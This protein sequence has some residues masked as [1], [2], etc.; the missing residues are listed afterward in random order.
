MF[1]FAVL[2]ELRK[3]EG[4][5]I[6]LVSSR[7][8]VSPAVISKLERNKTQAEL[9]TLFKLARVFGLSATDLLSLA[10]SRTAQMKRGSDYSSGDFHFQRLHYSNATA[11]HGFAEAGAAVSRP[12][13]HRDE[14]EICWALKGS[15][16]IRLPNETHD[17]A[18]GDAVQ[19]DAVLEHTY[20]ALEDCE[21]LILHLSKGKRF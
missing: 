3:R 11:F 9:E 12:E 19:F 14:Y 20:E 2:R 5:T 18:A 6:E 15:L 16:R 13:I 4:Y 7:S 10:E 21:L 1:D 8:G 17:L